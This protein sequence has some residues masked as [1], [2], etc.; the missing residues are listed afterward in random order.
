MKRGRR[1]TSS[2]VLI[3]FFYLSYMIFLSS[4]KSTESKHEI[5]NKTHQSV[6]YGSPSL[7]APMVIAICQSVT[8]REASSTSSTVTLNERVRSWSRQAEQLTTMLKT[9][10]Y[11]TKSPLWRIIVMTD[12]L[13]TFNKVLNLTASLPRRRLLLQHRPIWLPRNEP[14]IKR[15]WRPCAWAKQFMA[16][17]L[18]DQDSAV[19]VDTDVVFL[20]P[21]EELWW[22]LHSM[23]PRQALALA[24]EPQYLLDTPKRPFAGRVGLNT[25]VMVANLTR[26]RQL[27]G[28][29]LG[30]AIL[31]FGVITP[32]P[33]H[34]QDALNH[35]LL[36]KPHL[37]LELVY[38]TMAAMKLEDSP[39]L[40]LAGLAWR[41]AML[42][43][44]SH[45]YICSNYTNFN[46][47]LTLALHEAA[48]E[49]I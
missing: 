28:G 30:S 42:D 3:T 8:G 48:I 45:D 16:E 38:A 22:L 24:P 43:T 23:G 19:Y 17:A 10:L 18:P 15:H 44:W 29:G 40:L 31:D 47:G 6:V 27:P 26:L 5:I 11:F 49:Q 37:L 36:H 14:V 41:L 2:L 20:G 25:G 39:R 32:P 21:A 46:Q 1:V 35:Y 34:D 13:D 4:P 33:R 7:K 12:T 9:L